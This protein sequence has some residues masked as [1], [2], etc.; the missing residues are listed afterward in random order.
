MVA[1]GWPGQ[2]KESHSPASQSWQGQL[3]ENTNKPQA[4]AW[5]PAIT[6]KQNWAISTESIWK[7]QTSQDL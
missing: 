5:T 6:H 1:T 3:L 2:R 4:R 7:W